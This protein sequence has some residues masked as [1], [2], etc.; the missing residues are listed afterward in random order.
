MR[1]NQL[2][3]SLLLLLITATGLRA[4]TPGV[5]MVSISGYDTMK[6]SVTKIEASPGQ[7][8]VVELKNEGNLPKESMGH[9]W[10][11]LNA[12]TN[13]DAYAKLAM[14][15]KAD[16]YQP[17]PLAGKVLASIPVLGPKESA[18]VSFT[19]PLAPGT[20]PYLCSFPAH[21]QAGMKGVLIVK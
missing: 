1:I 10:V 19:A 15:A 5:K 21:C 7:K 3:L 4:G 13:P 2:P 14:T 11:L 20:Y 9:N 18:R 8:M 16:N 17:K 12:G 6:Y